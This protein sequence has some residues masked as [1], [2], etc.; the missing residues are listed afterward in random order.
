M[1]VGATIGSTTP[2][3]EPKAITVVSSYHTG[4]SAM[5]VAPSEKAPTPKTEFDTW[6]DKLVQ[7]ES[8]GKENLKILD[9]NGRYSYG[10]L[11]FQEQTF[12]SYASSYG[13]FDRE[14]S[15]EPAIYSCALQKKIAK[16]MFEDDP[17]NW[18][19]WYTSVKKRGLGVPPRMSLSFAA[20]RN[21]D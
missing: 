21:S 9:V 18:R 17:G 11:Q 20:S 14:D 19:H 2:L 8:D 5:M 12:R 1:A 10:C 7:L 15:V 16:K 6:L 13:L 4:S 3:V